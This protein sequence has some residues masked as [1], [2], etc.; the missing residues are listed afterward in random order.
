M[1]LYWKVVPGARF[2]VYVHNGLALVYPDAESAGA[3]LG[4][5]LPNCEIEPATLIVCPTT[6]VTLSENVTATLVA[7]A[8]ATDVVAVP[9]LTALLVLEEGLV[10]VVGVDPLPPPVMA[11]S[12][13]LR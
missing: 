8:Q 13:Q 2:T 12:A 1:N 6:V 11:I 7:S 9:V 3:E 4:S 5:Q 10:V